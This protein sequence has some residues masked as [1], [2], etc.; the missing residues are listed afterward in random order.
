M[1]QDY[2]GAINTYAALP[3]FW[4]AGRS[5]LTSMRLMAVAVGL[6]TP[7]PVVPAGGSTSTGRRPRRWRFCCCPPTPPLC[8]EPAGGVCHLGHGSYW[9]GRGAAWLRW[10]RTGAGRYALA[11]AFL[12][13]FGP[14]RQVPLCMAH[15]CRWA[16][17]GLLLGRVEK[18]AA[19]TEGRAASLFNRR[20]LA[21]CLAAFLLGACPADSL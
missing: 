7:V 15:R 12:F 13:G 1:T 14:V 5:N 10:A 2:I 18:R 8:L 16:L 21:G 20:S 17:A 6:I 19:G 4:A 3:F 9:A 11:G